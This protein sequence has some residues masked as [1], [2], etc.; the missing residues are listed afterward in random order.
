MT[1]GANQSRSMD[2]VLDSLVDRRRLRCLNTVDEF[3]GESLAVEVD[4]SLPSRRVI[5][6][7]ELL[8]EM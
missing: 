5:S 7:L 2:L 1:A 4:T 8:A 6:V 3:T